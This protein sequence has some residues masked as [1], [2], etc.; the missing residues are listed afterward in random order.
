MNTVKRVA[1]LAIKWHE[2]KEKQ[3]DVTE[4]P[5]AEEKPKEETETEETVCNGRRTGASRKN[6]IF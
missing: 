1:P 2:W 6:A 4:Q 5:K 3:P